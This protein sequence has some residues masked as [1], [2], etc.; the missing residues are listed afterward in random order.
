MIVLDIGK[1][2]IGGRRPARTYLPIHIYMY[3]YGKA[4]VGMLGITGPNLDND[5]PQI[6]GC[7]S[8][9]NSS[10]TKPDA[11]NSFELLVE[12]KHLK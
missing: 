8:V 9:D 11:F 1:P 7:N 12:G 10:R 3:V 6:R 5:E 2:S 4:R